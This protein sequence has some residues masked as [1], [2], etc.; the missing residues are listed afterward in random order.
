VNGDAV[1]GGLA[2]AVGCGASVLPCAGLLCTLDHPR[3][4]LCMAWAPGNKVVSGSEDGSLRLW[5]AQ[6]RAH[7]PSAKSCCACCTMLH[8][9]LPAIATAPR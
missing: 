7:A 6:V 8:Q 3:R 2:D 9:Y 4:A 1:G 5:D